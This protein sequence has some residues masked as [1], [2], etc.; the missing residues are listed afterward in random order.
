LALAL[1]CISIA[2]PSSHV[3]AGSEAKARGQELFATKGC[4]HC[5]GPAGVGGPIGPDLQLIRKR[6]SAADIAKQIHDGGRSMPAFGDQLSD[7]EINDL[8]AYL[9]A[10]R[11]IIKSPPAAPTKSSFSNS[12]P[13]DTI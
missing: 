4:A 8:V 6:M 13:G 3:A 1:A 2:S 5:H 9:R 12:D 10:K 11:R 7:N